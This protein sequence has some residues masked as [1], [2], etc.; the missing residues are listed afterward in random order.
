MHD[1]CIEIPKVGAKKQGTQEIEGTYKKKEGKICS[2]TY[3]TAQL[4]IM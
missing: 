4:Y 1:A 2:Y 3:K